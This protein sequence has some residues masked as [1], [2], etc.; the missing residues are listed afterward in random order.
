M[1]I[2]LTT[3]IEDRKA[4]WCAA[5]GWRYDDDGGYVCALTTAKAL[6]E[7]DTKLA[8]L[9]RMAALVDEWELARGDIARNEF[10]ATER[11]VTAT[12]ALAKCA[13]EAREKRNSK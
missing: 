10:G 11:S 9:S 6:A 5:Y 7:K 12:I 4:T 8:D 2:P 1:P 3:M 13:R